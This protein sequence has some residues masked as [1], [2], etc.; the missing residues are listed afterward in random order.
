LS[1]TL[2]STVRLICR[3]HGGD[4]TR[5]MDIA[6]D[7]QERF[8]CVSGAAMDHSAGPGRNPIARHSDPRC[9]P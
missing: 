2:E 7:V 3:Q 1:E 6:R 9:A 8:G 5:L 4:P